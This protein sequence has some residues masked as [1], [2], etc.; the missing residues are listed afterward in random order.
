MLL[1]FLQLFLTPSMFGIRQLYLDQ[2]NQPG[3]YQHQTN[4]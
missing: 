3:N 2:H 1:L 4:F